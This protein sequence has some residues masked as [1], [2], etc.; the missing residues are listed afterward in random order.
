MNID[1]QRRKQQAVRDAEA[2]GEIADSMDVRK[3]LISR[4]DAGELTLEQVQAELKKI[5]RGA[6][7]AGK[8]TRAGAY[9]HG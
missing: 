5:K 4:M 8:T 7:A 2:A 9:R 6:K 1:N 3:A